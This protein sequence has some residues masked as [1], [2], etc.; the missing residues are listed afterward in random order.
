M[1]MVLVALLQTLCLIFGIALRYI[2][3]RKLVDKK[4]KNLLFILY[5]LILIV[6]MAIMIWVCLTFDIS[7]RLLQYCGIALAL[8]TTLVNFLVIKKRVKEHFF[9]FG[10]VISYNYLLMT[11]PTYIIQHTVTF[12]TN[13]GYLLFMILNLACLLLAFIPIKR[14]LEKTVTPFLKLDVEKYWDTIWF[15]PIALLIT[16]LLMMPHDDH[17]EPISHLLSHLMLVVVVTLICIS[18][19]KDHTNIAEKQHMTEQISK[20]KVY[21]AG[22]KTKLDDAKKINHDLK[23]LLVSIRHYIETDDKVG[24]SSFCDDVEKEYLNNDKM[25]YTGNASIDGVIYHYLQQ[26]EVQNIDFQYSGRIHSNGL[27]E[28]DLC[29]LLG[30]ALDNAFTAA[31]TSKEEKSVSMISQTEEN[32]LSI[33]IQN[34][35]DG[36]VELKN[37]TVFSRKRENEEGLG[38]KQMKTICEKYGG[39]LEIMWDNDKFNL[40]IMLPLNR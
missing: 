18:I 8:L 6:N 10:I 27:G 38:L 39:T 31:I 26:A 19:S 4:Q 36:Y 1:I 40:F 15:I 23:H 13:N 33:I 21:Y 34:T 32:I 25:P 5:S 17:I 11:I 22:L 9:V 20:E 24:L 12:D 30:N 3:F 29:V 35:F 16:M 37:D 7:K 28:M 2:P 14:V